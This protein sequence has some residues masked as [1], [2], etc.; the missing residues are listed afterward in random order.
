LPLRDTS[1]NCA[2]SYA[3]G[4]STSF[5]I[6]LPRFSRVKGRELSVSHLVE[7]EAGGAHLDGEVA[8]D[9][10]RRPARRTQRTELR[11]DDRMGAQDPRK[12]AE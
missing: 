5:F 4:V 8:G 9:V 11:V 1:G 3:A 12:E 10:G 7:R 6:F 2:N